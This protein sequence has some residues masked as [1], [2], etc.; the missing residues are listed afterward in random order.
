M[1]LTLHTSRI[2]E[3]IRDIDYGTLY[4]FIYLLFCLISFYKEIFLNSLQN[5][6]LQ[7]IKVKDKYI[8]RSICLDYFNL[9]EYAY[10]L[11]CNHSFHRDCILQWLNIKKTCPLCRIELELNN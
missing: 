4:I 5:K 1:N 2:I 6:Y 10:I 9:D 11:K 7:K 8:Q 3:T